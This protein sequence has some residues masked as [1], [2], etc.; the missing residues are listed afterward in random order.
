MRCKQI[1]PGILNRLPAGQIRPASAFHQAC[2]VFGNLKKVN[3]MIDHIIDSK[4]P[5]WF[6]LGLHLFSL[7]IALNLYKNFRVLSNI[8]EIYIVIN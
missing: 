7:V 8:Y 3:Q 5:T 4:N 6:M 2:R 1:R